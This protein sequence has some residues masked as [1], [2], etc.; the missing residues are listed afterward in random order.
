MATFARVLRGVL[1]ARRWGCRAESAGVLCPP[2]SPSDRVDSAA[3]LRPDDFEL[4]TFVQ[5]L[6]A[7]LV[8]E[9]DAGARTWLE[10]ALGHAKGPNPARSRVAGA[11]AGAGRRVGHAPSNAVNGLGPW[12]SSTGWTRAEA[13][14]LVLIAAA[15]AEL[16]ADAAAA[17]V[18][19]LYYRGS[20]EEQRSVVRALP[21]LDA[22][23]RSTE[24]A[25]DA[26]RT[27]AEPVFEALACENVYP[28]LH[29]SDAAFDQLLLKVLFTG[30]DPRRVCGV[31]RRFTATTARRVD[32]LVAERRAA[33]RPAPLGSDWLR[34]LSRGPR[35][36]VA[37]E[38]TP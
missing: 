14:R 25:V 24:L 2:M 17:F 36:G 37:S 23:P 10:G 34:T 4:V 18:E 33:G 13:V 7:Q 22:C 12:P 8:E 30:L 27:N 11:I 16:E 31:E 29:F 32:D 15:C 38:G 3:A 28:A 5:R 21:I 1:V 35:D 19:D 26:G 6:H 20:L 9:L